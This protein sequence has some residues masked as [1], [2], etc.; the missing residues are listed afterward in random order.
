MLGVDGHVLSRP[1]RTQILT[2]VLQNCQKTAVEKPVKN[3]I[4]IGKSY[5]T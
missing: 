1:P 2:V 3:V 5:V 4:G